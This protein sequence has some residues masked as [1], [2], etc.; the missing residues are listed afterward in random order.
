[1]ESKS[2]H[3][4]R[5]I[6]HW[7]LA[8][9]DHNDANLSNLK[10]QKLLYYSQGHYLGEHKAPLFEDDI[11]AWAHGP[12]VRSVYHELKKF[13]NGP[14]DVDAALPTNFSWD[15]FRDVENDLMRVWNT[16]GQYEAWAL[17]NRTHRETPWASTFESGKKFLV[18]PKDS[19]REY[20]ETA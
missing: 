1:M 8:W 10:L 6:T 20:F 4:A 9:A 16:Y 17:R 12:V 7:F 3:T 5:D 2:P 11:E 19:M 15:D 18:I 13:G 14:I